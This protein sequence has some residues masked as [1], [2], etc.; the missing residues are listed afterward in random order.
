MG[1]FAIAK[2][3]GF[4]FG[5][6][7][8]IS[9]LFLMAKRKARP[10]Q[11]TM[12]A[13]LTFSTLMWN[14]GIFISI[15]CGYLYKGP[16]LVG[17]VFDPIA[18][19]GFIMLHPLM[20]HTL[21]DFMET[22]H[23]V[24][25]R[26]FIKYS[27]LGVIYLPNFYFI[28]TIIY[29]PNFPDTWAI[30]QIIIPYNILNAPQYTSGFLVWEFILLIVSWWIIIRL[31]R[32]VRDDE[33][34]GFLD[35]LSWL[36]ALPIC[37]SFTTLLLN[38]TTFFFEMHYLAYIGEYFTL[39]CEIFISLLPMLLGYY[40]YRYN[41]LEYIFKR[42]MIYTLIGIF[43]IVLYLSFIR[44]MGE[45]MEKYFNV[46]VGMLQGILVMLL[47]FFFD[48]LKRILQELPNRVFF[49]ESL[50]YRKVLLD[51]PLT[52]E[53]A[54]YL[55][56]ADLLDHMAATIVGAL[57]IRTASFV[58]LKEGKNGW[59]ITDSTIPISTFDIEEIIQYTVKRRTLV[60]N[61]YDLDEHDTE[62]LRQMKNLKAFTVIPIQQENELIG[63]LILGKR[64]MRN[65]LS[66]EEEEILIMSI[67]QMLTA[68]KNTRLVREKFILERKMY[69][70]DK[71][72]SLGRLSAS[73]AHEVKNPL[74]SIKAI[75]QVMQ[76]DLPSEDPNQE[77]LALVV[78]QVDRLTR[79]VQQLLDF[80]RPQ[81]FTLAPVDIQ[82]IIFNVL[83]LLKHEASRNQVTIDNQITEKLELKS[84]QDALT[85]IFFNL[86]HNSIQAMPEGGTVKIL[87]EIKK[88]SKQKTVLMVSIADNGPGIPS[89]E[90]KKILEPFYTTKQTGT[91]LGLSIVTK[92][93][94]KLKGSIHIKD[95]QPGALFEIELP[96]ERPKAEDI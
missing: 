7:L 44:P 68:I 77:G 69:E 72:S 33:E 15:F 88:K 2:I 87:K 86:L 8:Q 92:R 26:K 83:M 73:I 58:F 5:T 70:N 12:F 54:T 42:A 29:L 79:V 93:L 60:F 27:I 3:F 43:V 18:M 74:S 11:E 9:I 53:H 22:Q 56:M 75:T 14:F 46:N 66:G 30:S 35:I 39:V 59:K 45:G 96:Y 51:I 95:N 81:P 34:I 21:L 65:H 1:F 94:K 4:L 49:R 20:V 32:W 55:D 76:E 13:F 19:L 71:L 80:A 85:E 16:N 84:D 52:I 61:L 50:Y 90:R 6:V 41:Y 48:P 36:V 31:S 62:V 67:N 25:V 38:F 64:G 10:R 78:D 57:K 37:I 40:L 24:E 28:L 91:G 23:L 63:L 82:K 89:K 47:V 17:R